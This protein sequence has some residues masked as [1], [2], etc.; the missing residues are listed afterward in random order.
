M[1]T[2]IL[3]GMSR[4]G[5][6]DDLKIIWK[7]LTLCRYPVQK[8]VKLNTYVLV[9]YFSN[10]PGEYGQTDPYH[11]D[12]GPFLFYLSSSLVII[13]KHSVNLVCI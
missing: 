7:K 3:S 6:H 12:M 5:L 1:P 4:H 11:Y 8:K 2:K 9:K 13:A 10:F